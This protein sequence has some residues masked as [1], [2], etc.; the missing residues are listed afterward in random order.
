MRHWQQSI[1][2]QDSSYL[3]ASGQGRWGKELEYPEDCQASGFTPVLVVLDPTA[4]VKLDELNQAFIAAGGESYIG[5]AAWGHL[6]SVAGPT[7]ARFLEIYVHSPL[8]ELLE[9]VP[10]ELPDL[11]LRMSNDRIIMEIGEEYLTIERSKTEGVTTEN[12]MLPEDVDEEG[13]T[14]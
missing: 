2:D 1:R 4:N 11:T 8:Q 7:M 9:E 5:Q 12:D 10:Q 6:A 14:A 3:A 13:P